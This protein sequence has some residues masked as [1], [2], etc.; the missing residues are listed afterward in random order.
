MVIGLLGILKAG[1]AY[2][3][4]DASYPERRLAY[5]LASA[6]PL[7]VLTQQ[8]LQGLPGLSAARSLCLD[9]E[10]TEIS[11]QEQE[12]PG[13][14]Y[15]GLNPSDL[16]YLI[17]TSGS[18]GEPKGVMVEH[19]ALYNYFLCNHQFTDSTSRDIFLQK[20]SIGFDMSLGEVLQPLV[21]GARLV[22]AKPGGQ[23]DASYLADLIHRYKVTRTGFVPSLLRTLLPH[24]DRCGSIDH[25]VC[26]GE[27][28]SADLVREFYAV[29]RADCRLYNLYGP[30]E[31]TIVVSHYTVPRSGCWSTAPIGKP[32]SNVLFYVLDSSRMPVPV[33]VVGELYVGG[34]CLARG[35]L[36][37]PELTQSKFIANPL[38]E[39]RAPRLYR[40]GDLVRWLPEG[41]LEFIGRV[42]DQVKV[43]GYRIELGEIESHLQQHEKVGEAIVMV[44]EGGAVQG[45]GEKRLVAYITPKS[46]RSGYSE[47]LKRAS[48]GMAASLDV[49]ALHAHLKERVPPYMIPTAFVVLER[50]PLTANGKVD[51]RALPSPTS[52]AYLR[53]EYA[54]PQGEIEIALAQIW[55]ELLQ[56]E[57]VGRLDDF[58]ALGGHSLLAVRATARIRDA[59][60]IDLP[61]RRVFEQST[62]ADMAG[63]ILDV[64]LEGQD[65]SVVASALEEIGSDAGMVPSES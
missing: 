57:Q 59:F 3:P 65:A 27:P 37:E 4:L 64:L 61:L 20:M 38:G 45:T 60:D 9:S 1:G 13:R 44:R 8:A 54:P 62:L 15:P 36:N 31:T 5:L 28:L 55:Q 40:T 39:A 11:S 6:S 53:G 49:D 52:E 21:A 23:H 30:T 33:G 29:A 63:A 51:R 56:A 2:L 7:L 46:Q 58:F 50:M 26:G 42:D 12:N 10:W 19:R 24:W 22:I 34:E 18:T 32:I 47:H 16:A 17:Y 25:L 48:S 43:R 14:D 41:V 35:Y